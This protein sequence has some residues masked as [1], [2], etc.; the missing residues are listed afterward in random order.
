MTIHRS[1]D[2]NYL[3]YFFCTLLSVCV[4]EVDKGWT[5]D[6][7]CVNVESALNEFDI[8]ISEL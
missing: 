3:E 2:Y 8:S 4:C 1:K 5:L 6:G 7:H